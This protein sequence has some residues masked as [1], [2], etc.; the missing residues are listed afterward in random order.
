MNQSVRWLLLCFFFFGS[1]TV[2]QAFGQD[3]VQVDHFGPLSLSPE[4]GIQEFEFT[5]P[6]PSNPHFLEIINGDGGDV[7]LPN[8]SGKKR[9]AY[10][11]CLLKRKWVIFRALF[12]RPYFVAVTLNEQKIISKRQW[13][14]ARGVIVQEVS[15]LSENNLKIKVRGRRS[16]SVTV[17]VYSE[18]NDQPPVAQFSI[19]AD[20]NDPN[21]F[22]FDGS[23]S[24]DN[25][26][27]VSYEWDFGDGNGATGVQTSHRYT[28]SGQFNVTLRVTDDAGLFNETSQQ[29]E[30]VA[31]Q[32]PIA[33][34]SSNITSGEAPLM[35][36]FDASGSSDPDGDS[37][38]Y[39]W[40][41]GDGGTSQELMPAHLFESPGTFTV[42]LTVTDPR[43]A[44]SQASLSIEA[45][46]LVIPP[47]PSTIAPP[48][49]VGDANGLL[50]SISFLY[51]NDPPV[52][53]DASPTSFDPSLIS[54]VRGKVIDRNN[55]PIS[56]IKVSVL[57]HTEFGFT[58]T[59][60]DGMYDLVV[61]GGMSYVLVFDND[62]FLPVQRQ[63]SVA[64]QVSIV[65]EDVVLTNLDPKV[66]PLTNNAATSQVLVGSPSTDADG[67]RTGVLFVPPNTS[68][69]VVLPDGSRQSLPSMSVR[70][71]EYTVGDTGPLA[72][73][74]TLPPTTDY[75]YAMELS[76]DQA[77]SLGSDRVEF[78]QP[79]SY[80]V[81]NFL[82]FPAGSLVPFG[83]YNT[84][85]GMWEAEDNGIVVNVISVNN[86]IAEIDL[87]GSGQRNIDFE[88]AFGVS[89]EELL[90]IGS[91]YQ[92]GDSFWRV[93]VD[94][95]SAYDLNYLKQILNTQRNNDRV[96]NRPTDQKNKT[97]RSGG[98]FFELETQVF[99]ETLPVYG[100]PFRLT[101]KSDRVPGY[102]ENARFRLD[103]SGRFPASGGVVADFTVGGREISELI[104]E[105][106]P[107]GAEFTWDG[108]D[109]FG[110]PINGLQRVE[111]EVSTVVLG[112]DNFYLIGDCSQF[113]DAQLCAEQRLFGQFYDGTLFSGRSAAERELTRTQTFLLGVLDW[114]TQGFG[115][116]SL[117]V[118]HSFN[119]VA[120]RL[121][122]GDGITRIEDDAHVNPLVQSCF[123]RVGGC[124]QQNFGDG[125][126]AIKAQIDTP[127]HMQFL[128][129][130]RLLIGDINF[131]IDRIRVINTDGV[132]DTLAGN[133]SDSVSDNIQASQV[134]IENLRGLDQRAS[135][136]IIFADSNRVRQ[137]DLNGF[138]TTIAG[139]TSL[140]QNSGD[141][142]QAV[143]AGFAPINDLAVGVDGSIYVTT[144][145]TVRK[146]TP[147]GLVS[148]VAGRDQ[149]QGLIPVDGAL[150]TEADFQSITAIDVDR[151][152]N[153]FIGD[154]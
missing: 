144:G 104:T 126:E 20:P 47:D 90:A 34:I 1:L 22:S 137:I 18:M 153:L 134:E 140:T 6:N 43:G 120:N 21:Q 148:T 66:L 141:G 26:S 51:L 108:L 9:F 143:D 5:T 44:S 4:R 81:D 147:D 82:N 96:M 116:W 132:I 100:T 2:N 86:G 69:E 87:D 25:G 63:V 65:S 78:N 76:V 62:A 112:P 24:T 94:H 74:G 130:G 33:A 136:E 27:I 101:Y 13:P 110:R 123:Q 125:D 92:A 12:E 70:I 72:M 19:Q 131:G 135:G 95:F 80:Y 14:W 73:P 121:Y 115:G 49:P 32:T 64:R 41:F 71:T 16:S 133:G 23:G 142:G 88:Q 83:F 36:M 117:D 103:L 38:T 7:A 57:N 79:I 8:C 107:E 60:P 84:Q 37:L 99:G 145:T 11:S 109:A 119:P 53:R 39:L 77:I 52:Q 48:L 93:Q 111:V 97:C 29:V 89:G 124:P 56:G 118:H 30:V 151:D 127:R 31:N 50:E 102:V 105:S 139:S 75:T 54:W 28:S 3:N 114:R 46:E 150:A 15:V 85:T 149:N 10:L 129:D 40:D 113:S 67:T 146:I 122:R 17:R 128:G 138:V 59:R 106:R 58:V 55:Q 98:S 68:G 61:N 35:V 91:Q 45:T 154:T 152:G 42:T